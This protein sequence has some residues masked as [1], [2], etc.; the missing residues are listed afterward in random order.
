MRSY[1]PHLVLDSPK[2]PQI[3]TNRR[4]QG[5]GDRGPGT[6]DRGDKWVRKGGGAG[7]VRAAQGRGLLR[8]IARKWI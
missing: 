8:A 7:Q 4:R 3:V 2:G 5:T 6:R 1:V